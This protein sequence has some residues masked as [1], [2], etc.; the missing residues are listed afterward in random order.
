MEIVCNLEFILVPE[1][2][3]QTDGHRF[4]YPA[5]PLL[6][7]GGDVAP[8]ALCPEGAGQGEECVHVKNVKLGSTVELVMFDQGEISS[9]YIFQ[10][11]IILGTRA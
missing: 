1:S 3:G 11:M 10:M 2:W 7:Q 4:T 8:N 9:V 5:S 6:T